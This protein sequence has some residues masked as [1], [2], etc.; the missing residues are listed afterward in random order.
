MRGAVQY[1]VCTLFHYE[2]IRQ[3]AVHRLSDTAVTRDPA[4]SPEDFVFSTYAR[5]AAKYESEGP[6]RL[7]ARFT[8]E[9]AEHLRETR[10]SADQQIVDLP[11]IRSVEVT[12]TVESDQTLRWWLKA[13][14]SSVE[15]MEPAELREEIRQEAIK[16]ASQY[17]QSPHSSPDR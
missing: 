15:V 17:G 13:F 2:D 6:I 10:L 12:A 1:L 11:D 14:G 4:A 16:A 5:A 7:V 3:L 8:P 9:A